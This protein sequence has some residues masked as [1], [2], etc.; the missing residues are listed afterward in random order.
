[1]KICVHLGYYRGASLVTVMSDFEAVMPDSRYGQYENSVPKGLASIADSHLLVPWCQFDINMRRFGRFQRSVSAIC[2]DFVP[3]LA[4]YWRCSRRSG[5]AISEFYSQRQCAGRMR[6][7]ANPGRRIVFVFFL[8]RKVEQPENMP[9]PFKNG[10]QNFCSIVLRSL[11]V[12]F[13]RNTFCDIQF[14]FDT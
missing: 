12:K 2:W 14:L 10:I 5:A 11:L 1:M 4:Q 13:Y 9:E 7:E 3:Q 6:F 8:C